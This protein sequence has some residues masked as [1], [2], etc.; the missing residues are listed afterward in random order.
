M[1]AH[2]GMNW[3][4]QSHVDSAILF[5]P[6][7]YF[8]RFTILQIN[9]SDLEIF[10]SLEAEKNPRNRVDFVSRELEFLLPSVYRVP[11]KKAPSPRIARRA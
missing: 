11:S 8:D 5:Y 4:I 7:L 1:G 9:S 6:N 3:Q 10:M 2:I